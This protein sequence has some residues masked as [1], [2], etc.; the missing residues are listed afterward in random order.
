MDIDRKHV[1]LAL[2]VLSFG[3]IATFASGFYRRDLS[4]P[5]QS[6]IGYGFPLSW[7][8]ES[9]IVIPDPPTVYYFYWQFFAFDIMFWSLIATG[10]VIFASRWSRIRGQMT[11]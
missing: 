10:P 2:V 1:L 9:W 5:G 6:I 8:E 4:W 3:L 7:Y 11:K